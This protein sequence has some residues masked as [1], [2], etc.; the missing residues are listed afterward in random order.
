LQVHLLWPQTQSSFLERK[1]KELSKIFTKIAS[2]LDILVGNEEGF[3]LCRG[4][5]KPEACVEGSGE[6]I[7]SYKKMI[8]HVKKS[9]PYTT[10]IAATIREEVNANKHHW[11][12][13]MLEG[14]NWE[15]C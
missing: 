13:I 1:G 10:L 3:Q 4:I 15:F 11:G 14:K 8:K 12:G 2:L 7:D 5:K 6:K 9:F